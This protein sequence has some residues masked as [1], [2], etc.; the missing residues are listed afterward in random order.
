MV[1]RAEAAGKRRR[2]PRRRDLPLLTPRALERAR[3]LAEA[4]VRHDLPTYT[5]ALAFRVLVS[6]VPL[7]LLGLAL[8]GELGLEGVWRDEIGPAIRDR[9]TRPVFR[10]IDHSVERI[11][12]TSSIGLIAFA[13]GLLLWQLTRAMRTVMK[14]LNAIHDVNETRSVWRIALVDLGLALASGASVVASILLVSVLP[15]LVDGPAS[16]A[17]SIAA[18]V[19]AALLLAVA[20]GVV[21]RY[22]PAERPEVR[23]ASRGSVV[24]V[25]T[26]VCASVLF[27]WWAASIA[28]YKTAAG[29]LLVF[30]LLTAYV[31]VSSGIFLVG[32]E[33]D[34]L[35]RNRSKRK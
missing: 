19:V 15:R 34:E 28:N 5:A 23:W 30:L 26:W 22:A 2:E 13:G 3:P 18:W 16:M 14:A 6:L 31:L 17:M 29:S 1:R 27:G 25:A 9:V 7:T 33:L 11:F 4:F 12:T 24:V 32:V 8:L 21:V 20:A 35:A 10:G